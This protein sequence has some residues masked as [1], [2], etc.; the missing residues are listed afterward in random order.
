[1]NYYITGDTHGGFNRIKRFC[2]LIQTAPSDVMVILGDAGINYWCDSRDTELKDRLRDLNI[3][4]FCVHGNHEAR[5]WETGHYIERL[6]H[7]GTVYVEEEYPNLLF[8]KDGE[9]YDFNGKSV[10]VLGGAYS[11]D[12]WYRLGNGACWYQ[13]EQPTDEIKAYVQEQLDKSDWQVDIVLSHTVP[14]EFEP[15]W[16]F[17]PGIDQSQVDKSTELWLQTIYDKLK[18]SKWYAGHYHVD[19]YEGNIHIMYKDIED[20]A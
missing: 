10:L 6:W 13:S 18:F 9:I 3:T 15:T 19:S 1:M 8:A 17:L 4:L 20:L 2:N 14:V 5:P 12:K 7:G 16:A 11:I